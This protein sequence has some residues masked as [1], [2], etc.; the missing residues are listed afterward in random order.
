MMIGLRLV[1]G[2]GRQGGEDDGRVEGGTNRRLE[3]ALR[4]VHSTCVRQRAIISLFN[5]LCLWRLL[6]HQKQLGYKRSKN[7]GD[8]RTPA[9]QLMPPQRAARALQRT[10]PQG[11]RIEWPDPDTHMHMLET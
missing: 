3:Y 2:G 11:T 1:K 10:L 4:K 9:N 5:F 6:G 7:V 8:T